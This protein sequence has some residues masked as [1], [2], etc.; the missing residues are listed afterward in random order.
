MENV[1]ITIQ[2]P[3]SVS[4]DRLTP[5]SNG[6][7]CDHCNKQ[8]VDYTSMSDDQMM[9]YIKKH[10]IGCGSWRED[11]LG[12]TL[13]PS[14]RKIRVRTMAFY[15]PM[16]ILFLFKSDHAQAQ[17]VSDTVQTP[18]QNKKQFDNKIIE[19]KLDEPQ[20][21]AYGNTSKMFGGAIISRQIIHRDNWLRRLFRRKG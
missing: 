18:S 8:V 4:S 13:Y 1:S 10:G 6:H 12:R 5:N 17:A 20:R 15:L 11:Q 3:C 2:S 9:A 16:F 19:N 7:F 14:A 21:V